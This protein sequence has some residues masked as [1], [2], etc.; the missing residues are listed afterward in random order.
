[1]QASPGTV[2]PAHNVDTSN[3]AFDDMTTMSWGRCA[4]VRWCIVKS[5]VERETGRGPVGACRC[6]QAKSP[7]TSQQHHSDTAVAELAVNVGVL[8][9]T[10]HVR[11]S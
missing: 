9:G 1:M 8:P 5:V 2:S 6:V 3:A 10:A 4:V 7:T 11:K